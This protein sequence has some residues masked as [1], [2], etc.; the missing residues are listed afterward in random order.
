MPHACTPTGPVQ[1]RP[2]DRDG[3]APQLYIY[4]RR[5]AHS[6]ATSAFTRLSLI[7][8]ARR[9]NSPQ[10][11]SI[12]THPAMAAAQRLRASPM[13]AAV[14]VGAASM[15]LVTA[16]SSPQP[17]AAPGP[18]S[19]GRMNSACMNALLNMSDCLTFVEKGSTARFP[20]EPC[21]PELAGLV[22]SNPVCLCDLLA[23]AAGSYG[24]AIDY[25]RALTLPGI[26]R[27]STPPVSTCTGTHA[28]TH[29]LFLFLIRAVLRA[30]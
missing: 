24:I 14:F 18:A 19:G 11:T 4:T 1:L 16:A 25:H 5:S 10:P 13:L 29:G 17:A 7:P 2:S 3:R 30:R 15:L 28:R 26:C 20:E 22:G 8:T 27:V 23:G 6:Y 12:S 9:T 21:C